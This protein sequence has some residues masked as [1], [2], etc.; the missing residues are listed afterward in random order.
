MQANPV[1]IGGVLYATTPKLQVFALD[2]ATGE[3]L[4][5][6]DPT[7]GAKAEQVALTLDLARRITAA[8]LRWCEE[9]LKKTPAAR[10][11]AA[12]KRRRTRS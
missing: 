10:T 3:Q 2:A 7:S 8:H 4:W 6:F 12:S 9:I 1:V 5:R 11:R